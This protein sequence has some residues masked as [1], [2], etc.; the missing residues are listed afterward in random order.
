MIFSCKKTLLGAVL[1][2]ALSSPVCRAQAGQ[3]GS[4]DDFSGIAAD[5]IE[6]DALPQS[7]VPQ[8][9]WKKMKGW[10]PPAASYPSVSVPAG[11]D[12]A[13]WKRLRVI[14]VAEKYIGL[15]Y[16]HHHIP[17]WEPSPVLN[18]KTGAGLDCSNFTSWVYNYGLGI[19]FTSD[20]LK[21]SDGPLAPGRK[22][23]VGD[24]LEPGDL[25]FILRKNRSRVS[26]V[27]IYVD[28]GHII[29]STGPGVRLRDF[30]GRYKTHLS[31]VRRVIE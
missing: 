31:H 23:A 5:F 26:H 1:F 21:Q 12:P 11:K 14:A 30:K 17:G 24:K 25:I 15:A 4:S 22:L 28:E 10:G 9:E 13:V 2:L 29:D 16:R 8:S 20:I 6:R 3:P 19:K 7:S 18:K 27:V